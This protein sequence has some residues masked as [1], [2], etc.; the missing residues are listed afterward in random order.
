MVDEELHKTTCVSPDIQ[1]RTQWN[2]YMVPQDNPGKGWRFHHLVTQGLE[3]HPYANW[4]KDLASADAVLWLPTSTTQPPAPE[5]LPHDAKLLVLD[6]GDG[7]GYH[8][9][10][11]NLNYIVY[12]KRSWVKK[13]N[14]KYQGPPRR[15]NR[16]YFPMV[17]SSS[18]QYHNGKLEGLKSRTRDVV[19]SL[20]CFDRQPTRCRVLQWTK[21]AAAS[22]GLQNTMLGEVNHGGRKEINAGYFGAMRAAKIVVTCN[23][24]HWE[25]DFRL[26]EAMVSGA[27]VFVDEMWAP[28]PYPLRH[29]E[30]V[31][32]YNTKDQVAFTELLKYYI[33][34]PNEVRLDPPDRNA[35]P[36]C[37]PTD[38]PMVRLI[39]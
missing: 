21:D 9:K 25:G 17:Y 28:Q 37:A 10:A 24:S 12:F 18:D 5:T 30:H 8:P 31:I 6:E 11:A 35:S 23:P 16:N 13:S 15:L 27:L 33:E 19:C 39:L 38:R 22:L 7:E 4:T 2:V 20:R 14:G 34:H 26:F 3:K 36:A 29:K 1:F 32:I